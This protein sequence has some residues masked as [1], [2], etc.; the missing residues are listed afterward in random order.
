MSNKRSI[1]CTRVSFHPVYDLTTME[2]IG[3]VK[4]DPLRQSRKYTG[5]LDKTGT[6]GGQEF[7]ARVGDFHTYQEAEAAVQA[8]EQRRKAAETP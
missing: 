8:D 5:L 2:K 4:V 7:F 6:F 1:P 3:E